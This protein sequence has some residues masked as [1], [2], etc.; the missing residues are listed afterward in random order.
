MTELPWWFWV[1]IVGP[2]LLIIFG[3]AAYTFYKSG[4]GD[5]DEQ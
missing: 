4:K 5:D 1:F 3:G 2:L